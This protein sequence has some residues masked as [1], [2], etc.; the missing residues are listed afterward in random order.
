MD[1]TRLTF[2]SPN[3]YI[4]IQQTW[5]VSTPMG[6]QTGSNTD[7]EMLSILLLGY[8]CNYVVKK[9]ITSVDPKREREERKKERRRIITRCPR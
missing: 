6:S 1:T 4:Y 3:G 7:S 8:H 2:E 5:Y 9:V